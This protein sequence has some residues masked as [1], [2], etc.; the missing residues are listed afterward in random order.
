ML[1]RDLALHCSMIVVWMA[2]IHKFAGV[3]SLEHR[4]IALNKAFHNET[5]S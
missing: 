1:C 5:I 2:D 3:K 4:S